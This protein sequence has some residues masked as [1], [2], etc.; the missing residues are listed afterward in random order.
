MKKLCNWHKNWI[1][2]VLGRVIL[3]FV[4]KLEKNNFLTKIYQK[5][6]DFFCQNNAILNFAGQLKFFTNYYH[7]K[8]NFFKIVHVISQTY[9]KISWGKS[10]R[11]EK[12]SVLYMK[13]LSTK[14]TKMLNLRIFFSLD[15]TYLVFFLLNFDL[16][17]KLWTTL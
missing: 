10:R 15:A 1:G 8:F 17:N 4:K 6:V 3:Y 2:N 11:T 13:F 9:K 16:G 7:F 5:I 12:L 14:A